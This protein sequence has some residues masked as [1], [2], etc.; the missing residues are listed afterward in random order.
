MKIRQKWRNFAS[1]CGQQLL[2]INFFSIYTIVSVLGI[3]CLNK[4]VRPGLLKA[5]HRWKIL[6]FIIFS[7]KKHTFIMFSM[8]KLLFL[9][10]PYNSMSKIRG[11]I[12]ARSQVSNFTWTNVCEPN[13]STY[14]A[15]TNFQNCQKRTFCIFSFVAHF[16][17]IL[18]LYGFFF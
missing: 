5:G 18:F 15:R 6:N 11:L 8:K 3:N 13:N 1:K 16:K 4:I 17:Y 2:C 14:F 7:M 9:C 12:F 10:S